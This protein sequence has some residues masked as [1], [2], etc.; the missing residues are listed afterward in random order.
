MS[1]FLLFSLIT[2]AL[3]MYPSDEM[4]LS[5]FRCVKHGEDNALRDS[6][7]IGSADYPLVVKS[8][9][10]DQLLMALQN[11]QTGTTLNVP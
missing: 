7:V 9:T 4:H 8:D 6:P 5:M 3:I 1:T 2:G 10:A 11:S